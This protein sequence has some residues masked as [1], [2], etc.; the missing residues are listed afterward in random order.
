MGG[1][2]KLA[3]AVAGRMARRG[4]EELVMVMREP[5]AEE[6]PTALPKIY[7]NMRKSPASAWTG[8]L[9]ARQALAAY[10]PE[11]IHSH[12]FYANIF[13][14][15]LGLCVPGAA[16]LSTIH[17][18]YEGGWPRMMAYRLT[19]GFSRRSV[20]VSQ[21][22]SDRF[23]RLGAVPQDK[24]RVIANGIDLAEFVPEPAR[25]ARLREQ[26]GDS[27]NFVWITAG[28]VVPAKDY[29]NLLRAFAGVFRQRNE[30]RLWIAGEAASGALE[31]LQALAGE[32]KIASAVRWL[33]LRRDLPALL[34][35][36]DGFVLASAW[37]GMPLVL[38]EAMAMAKPVV[39]TDVGGV[40]E[41]AGETGEVV[42]AKDPHA[43]AAAMLATMQRG[44]E[45]RAKKGNAARERIAQ[46]F[47][48]EASADNWEAIYKEIL[49]G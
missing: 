39:A 4:H 33:G 37:E 13:G 17:N 12:S 42:A 45:V 23:V 19:D 29:P 6:W 10:R 27:A 34:D 47:S 3:L 49:A 31:P 24:C 21:A 32:L 36:A 43:L 2:E 38:G 44:Q 28:R 22:A 40:R 41:M 48:V 11:I 9:H 26:M 46:R 14:R 25:R 1:A 18:V 30:A 16:V 35:A 8:L 5:L 20:A 7:L 15:A